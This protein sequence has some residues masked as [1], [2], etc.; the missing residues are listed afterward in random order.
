MDDFIKTVTK[1]ELADGERP[2]CSG[3]LRLR[4]T[5]VRNGMV[6]MSIRDHL[7]EFTSPLQHGFYYDSAH[8][9]E[10]AAA[11]TEAADAMDE[12]A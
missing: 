5:P 10:I 9:R 12:N 1:R 8:L 6:V 7:G 4:I 3:V 11:L 2:V